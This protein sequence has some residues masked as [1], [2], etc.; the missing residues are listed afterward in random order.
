MMKEKLLELEKYEKEMLLLIAKIF[1]DSLEEFDTSLDN[2]YGYL[3]KIV[4]SLIMA[5]K[6]K[7]SY[8]PFAEIIEKYALNILT[9]KF[10]QNGFELLPLGYSS[11]L[12]LRNEKFILNID[13]KTANLDNLSDFKNTINLGINQITHIAKLPLNRKYLDSPYYV[14][15]TVPPYYDDTTLKYI[16]SFGLMFIYPSYKDLIEK[17]TKEYYEL[18]SFFNDKIKNNLIEKIEKKEELLKS[19]ETKEGNYSRLYLITESIIRGIFLHKIERNNIFR[20]LGLSEKE[21]EKI[22]NFEDKLIRFSS[23]L[24]ERKIKPIAIVCISIPNG[25]L[26]DYYLSDFRSGKSYAKSARYHYGKG[27]FKL[28]K[29]IERQEESRVL[30]IDINKQYIDKLKEIFKNIYL[31]KYDI[32]KI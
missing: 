4:L 8:N 30:F 16:L 13:I 21:I 17:V 9:K 19:L 18:F 10:Q 2:S 29:K 1:N 26:K 24:K 28:I 3:D 7:R 5:S 15:P 31:F 32:R 14:Y 12:T 11:D 6:N 27:I 25:L 22:K 20:K 23:N